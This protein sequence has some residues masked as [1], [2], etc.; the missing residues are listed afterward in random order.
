MYFQMKTKEI[1]AKALDSTIY[2]NKYYLDILDK[3]YSKKILRAVHERDECICNYCKF[4]D[5]NYQK[6]ISLSG[7][8]TD[9]DNIVTTCIFCEQI[10]AIETIEESRI[11]S[12]KKDTNE[13]YIQR[14]KGR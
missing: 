3:P 13:N 10:F 5:L 1:I 7:D 8:I 6:G 14:T 9:F 12:N 4:K 2:F 11:N